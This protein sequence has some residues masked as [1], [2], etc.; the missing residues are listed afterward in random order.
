[1]ELANKIVNQD[2]IEINKIIREDKAGTKIQKG[3]K[4]HKITFIDE[5]EKG[6][7]AHTVIEVE[8]WEKYNY[9]F[10]L[11]QKQQMNAVSLFDCKYQLQFNLVKNCIRLIFKY[12]IQSFIF[13]QQSYNISYYNVNIM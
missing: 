6:K 7:E 2:Q 3:V 9:V 13:I 8:C 12:Q 5:I 10:H 4:K 1:M 11:K